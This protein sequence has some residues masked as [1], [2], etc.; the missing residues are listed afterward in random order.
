MGVAYGADVAD[1]FDG[2]LMTR[3]V[4]GD[5]CAISRSFGQSVSRQSS[6]APN[7]NALG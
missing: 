4:I 3:P 5:R 1:T 7:G 2:D 6:Q